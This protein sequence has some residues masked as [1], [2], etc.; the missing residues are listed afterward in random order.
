MCGRSELVGE[1]RELLP[2]L[3]TWG[4]QMRGGVLS[5]LAVVGLL[6][7]Q[8]GEAATITTADLVTVTP[9]GV[10]AFD[11]SVGGWDGGGLV[12]GSFSG[13]DVDL[14]GQ[15]SAFVGEITAFSASYS[16]GAVIGPLSWVFADLFGLVYDLN[17]GPL[18][19]GLTLA[20]EGI[21]ATSGVAAFTI[22]PGP[23]AVCGTGVDCGIIDSDVPPVPEPS[24]LALVLAST[25]WLAARRMR[26]R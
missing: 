17:G 15:L 4:L 19:D 5:A 8:P 14:N 16:G 9:A 6:A 22:G 25:G 7:A 3:S 26:K 10:G 11:F 20:I 24:T 2:G 18:G 21:G 23:V 12:T 13:S 1:A